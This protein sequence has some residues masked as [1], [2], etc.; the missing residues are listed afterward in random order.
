MSFMRSFAATLVLLP[1]AVSARADTFRGQV[2]C[3]NCWTEADRKT[4]AYGTPADLKCAALCEKDK[5]PAALAVDEKGSFRLYRLEDGAFRRQGRG[6]LDY[7]AKRVEITGA[8]RKE[9][10]RDVL[11]VDSLKVLDGKRPNR[12]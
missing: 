4:T 12:P 9:K 8:V 10:D 2:V 6:W 5:V 1:L 7:I 3:S 11:R